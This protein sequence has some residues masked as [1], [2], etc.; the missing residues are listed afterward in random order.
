MKTIVKNHS[1]NIWETKLKPIWKLVIYQ[2]R[3]QKKQTKI[4]DQEAFRR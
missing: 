1:T 3:K 2:V 4:Q